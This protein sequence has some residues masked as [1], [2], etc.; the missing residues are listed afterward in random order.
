LG[1]SSTVVAP[2]APAIG[3]GTA[4]GDT[5]MSKIAVG[6]VPSLLTGTIDAVGQDALD[7]AEHPLDLPRRAEHVTDVR[8]VPFPAIGA[9]LRE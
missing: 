9:V 5:A 1:K 7:L 4:T 6:P 8:V 3:T 2:D